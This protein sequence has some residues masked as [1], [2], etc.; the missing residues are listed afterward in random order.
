MGFST[1]TE[2]NFKF[3]GRNSIGIFS[4]DTVI[5]KAYWGNKA[6]Q[7]AFSLKL[8]SVKLT[9]PKHQVFWLLISKGY[10]T[11][12]CMTNNFPR[13]YPSYRNNDSE[14]AEVVHHYCELL[15]PEYYNRETQI[16]DFGDDY[17]C[18][19]DDVAE[20]TPEMCMQDPNIR[21]FNERNLNWRRGTELPCCGEITFPALGA[22]LI[23]RATG[24]S[25]RGK[26]RNAGGIPQV[27]MAGDPRFSNGEMAKPGA[28][29]SRVQEIA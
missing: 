2:I 26:H 25:A 17:Q 4:G 29:A 20:I 3:K 5:E 12:L 7:T 28:A 13:H 1:Y 6:L 22:Q 15:F 16:L 14:L 19:Q 21:F 8:A 18:L 27:A 10:K 9:N 11:Y 23:K 24:K